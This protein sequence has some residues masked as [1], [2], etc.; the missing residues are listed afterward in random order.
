MWKDVTMGIVAK[1]KITQQIIFIIV[2]VL[3]IKVM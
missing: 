1:F 2:K 3:V